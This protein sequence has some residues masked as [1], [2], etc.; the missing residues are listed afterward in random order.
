MNSIGYA[1]AGAGRVEKLARDIEQ[2]YAYAM[3]DGPKYLGAIAVDGFADPELW[4]LG[5]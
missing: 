4:L 2:G 5:D 3:T 1:V